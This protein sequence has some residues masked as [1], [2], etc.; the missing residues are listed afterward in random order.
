[1]PLETMALFLLYHSLLGA[2]R[3]KYLFVI[4]ISLLKLAR[5]VANEL[6]MNYKIDMANIQICL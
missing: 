4:P 5:L 2:V 1:M 3:L 6:T